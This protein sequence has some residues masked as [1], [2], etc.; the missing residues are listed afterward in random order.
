M[1][2]VLNVQMRSA[3]EEEVVVSGAAP[4]IDTRPPKSGPT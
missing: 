2:V 3:F 4:T 1:A